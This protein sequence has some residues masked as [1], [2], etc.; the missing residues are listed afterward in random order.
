MKKP[1]PVLL[2]L[3]LLACG[4]SDSPPAA[5]AEATPAPSPGDVTSAERTAIEDKIR[6]DLERR[7]EQ[8]EAA[9]PVP[10]SV[11]GVRYGSTTTARMA[12]PESASERLDRLEAQVAGGEILAL[13]AEP[14]PTGPARAPQVPKRIQRRRSESADVQITT[15]SARKGRGSGAPVARN[16]YLSSSYSGGYG[17]REH[18]AAL[19][20]GGILLDGDTVKLEALAAQ[21]HQPVPVPT[22]RAV[23]LFTGTEHARVTVDGAETHLQIG[24]QATNKELPRRPP[25]RLVLAL[26]VSGSM[27]GEGKLHFAR[28]AALK[29][30]EMLSPDDHVG[31]VTYADNATVIR[32]LRRLHNGSAVRAALEGLEAGGSTNLHDGLAAAHRVL[33]EGAS[34]GV[35]RVLVL[36]D[37]EPTAGNTQ[38]AAI[39]RIV[40]DAFKAGIETT[41]LG[42]GLDF[43]SDLMMSLA[44]D[45][46]GNYH[47]I[48]APE[49]IEDVLTR[50]VDELSHVVAQALRLTIRVPDDVEIVEVLGAEVLDRQAAAKARSTEKVLDARLAEELGIASDRREEPEDGLKLLI[51]NFHLGRHHVVLLKVRVPPGR[52]AQ[53][54]ATVELKGKD[55]LAKA[56][57]EETTVVKVERASSRADMVSSLDRDVKKNLLG[58]R[59]GSALVQAGR[60][61]ETGTPSAALRL[62]DDQM[63]LLAVAGERWRDEDLTR[64]SV[65]LGRYKDVVLAQLEGG[66]HS[67]AR[68]YLSMS[69][70]YNGYK[71]MR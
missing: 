4:G 36:S 61:I 43:N 39:R 1:L 66:L 18:M 19:V 8:V 11:T 5:D 40:H 3:L 10:E 23:V 42:V 22:E 69:L 2:T 47:F 15:P 28:M 38:P 9:R 55:L 64:D 50:E 35:R 6:E 16:G 32:P 17:A 67:K 44:A 56:N 54:L 62:I 25:L 58:F 48:G 13:R 41:A 63:T 68:N 34:D 14:M 29:L 7:R 31:I 51:P 57:I 12:A 27:S 70:G 46:Q 21:Y 45:G 59:A 20:D 65:L 71:L 49:L 53:T 33:R 26:D 60:M 37:G 24:V 52:A 30:L